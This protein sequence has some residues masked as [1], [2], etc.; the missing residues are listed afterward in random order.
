MSVSVRESMGAEANFFSRRNPLSCWL[1][2]MMMCFAGC[3]L[4]NFVIG[5]PVISCFANNNEVFVVS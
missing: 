5:Q 2:S 1:S 4:T 3:L